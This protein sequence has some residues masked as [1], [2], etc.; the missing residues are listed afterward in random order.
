MFKRRTGTQFWPRSS[1]SR[2]IE[3]I[4]SPLVVLVLALRFFIFTSLLGKSDQTSQEHRADSRI[5]KRSRQTCNGSLHR[6]L[7]GRTKQEGKKTRHG[8]ACSFFTT[9]TEHIHSAHRTFHNGDDTTRA[10]SQGKERRFQSNSRR[11]EDVSGNVKTSIKAAQPFPE[12]PRPLVSRGGEGSRKNTRGWES[13]LL[14]LKMLTG[15]FSMESK[16][17]STGNRVE[18]KDGRRAEGSDSRP[19][20]VVIMKFVRRWRQRQRFW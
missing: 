10:E 14:N 3:R 13:F 17:S 18:S 7:L 4:I 2:E 16:D 8:G 6:H 19:C 9:H 11:P 12:G 1:L 20:F 15:V 5:P